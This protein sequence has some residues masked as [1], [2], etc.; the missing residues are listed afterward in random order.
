MV[1]NIPEYAKNYYLTN[2]ERIL[3]YQYA[4]VSCPS[5]GKTHMQRNTARH[6]RSSYHIKRTPITVEEP[7]NNIENN[8]SF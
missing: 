7:Q 2:K 1:T 5:C 4:L 6:N 8:E 3:A